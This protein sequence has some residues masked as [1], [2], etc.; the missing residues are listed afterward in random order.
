MRHSG[1]N[2]GGSGPTAGEELVERQLR[3]QVEE[4]QKQLR[5]RELEP[6]GPPTNHWRPSG[7]TISALLIGSVVL[8]IAA[9]F[10]GYVPLQHR[11]ALVMAEAVE[12][13]KEPPRVDVLQVARASGATELRLPATLQAAVEAPIL[14][15]ADGYLRKR[16]ADIGDRV[17]AGQVL[18]EIEAPEIDQQIRQ[19]EAV[20]A[21]A[22]AAE[23]QAQAN[24]AHGTANRDLA[25]LTAGRWRSLFTQGV[26]SQQ[27]N[28]QAQAQLVAQNANVQ[29]LEKAVLA[30]ASNVGAARANLARLQEIQGYRSVKAPFDGVVT[31]RNIDVGA[32]VTTG[33]TLLYRIAQTNA[34]RVYV[35]VPQSD[36]SSVHVGQPARLTLS[37]VPGRLFFGKVTRTANALDPASRTMLT[38]VEVPNADHALF[39]GMYGEISLTS[40]RGNPPLVIPAQALVVRADGSQVAVVQPDGTV[41]LQKVSVGR[42]YGDRVEI[43]QGLAEGTAILANAD[44]TARDGAKVTP[45]G[46][47]VP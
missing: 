13:E 26:V 7:L 16:L 15:R 27:D 3:R 30:Q 29:A 21:Q 8:F 35:N 43:I 6:S 33:T 39:P 25:S 23:E 36:A 19:A 1:S 46:V 41:R 40:A 14:A 11:D 9:F 10:A 47:K 45:V 42:D 31:V 38:E 4:L 2:E 44:D 12:R 18:A 28:D 22:Q 32:L 5:E 20:V 37:N 34:L 24:L 17:R